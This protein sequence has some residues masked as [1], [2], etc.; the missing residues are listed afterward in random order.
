[1]SLWVSYL[2]APR[3]RKHFTALFIFETCF[4]YIPYGAKEKA[5]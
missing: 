1:M 3:V 5:Q 2:I 4:L